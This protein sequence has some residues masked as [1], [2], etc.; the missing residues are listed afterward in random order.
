[1]QFRP[2]YHLAGASPLP[3]DLGYLLTVTPALRSHWSSATQPPGNAIIWRK[4]IYLKNTHMPQL[5]LSISK[6]IL[7]KSAYLQ[8]EIRYRL[9]KAAF[10]RFSKKQTNYFKGKMDKQIA[11][12]VMN[13]IQ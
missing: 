3:V 11:V 1:M 10:F 8:Q 12:S 7:Y 5:S 4:I 9:L 13:I 2:S 6:C